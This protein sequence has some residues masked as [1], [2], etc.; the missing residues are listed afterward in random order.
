MP[1]DPEVGTQLEIGH[2]LFIDA[3]GYSKLLTDEQRELQD[4]L[5][6]IVRATEQFRSADSAGKLVRFPQATEWLWCF[7]IVPRLRSSAPS[8]SSASSRT[9]RT[10]NYAS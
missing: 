9:F 7:S 6:Q 10:S 5:S 4:R 1:L 3:V 2:V 8:N